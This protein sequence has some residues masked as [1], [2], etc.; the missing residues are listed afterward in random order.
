MRHGATAEAEDAIRRV[1][2][3]RQR[4]AAPDRPQPMPLMP[5]IL[6]HG[7]DDRVVHPANQEHIARQWMLLNGLPCQGAQGLTVK[8]AARNKR[9]NAYE[10]RDYCIGTKPVLRVAR[11]AGLG[12]AW[13][14]GDPSLRFNA[15]AGPDASRMIL[16][17][18]RMHKR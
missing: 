8:T 12:H 14:G 16:D 15:P 6:I 13:S 9:R 10:L 1:V 4:G 2:Q 11:I 3:G 5:A 18:F 17:F 7:E